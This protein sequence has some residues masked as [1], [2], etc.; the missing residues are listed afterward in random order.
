MA[1]LGEK[2]KGPSARSASGEDI[3]WRLVSGEVSGK[4]TRQQTG[5]IFLIACSPPRGSGLLLH[6]LLDRSKIPPYYD[7]EPEIPQ[8]PAVARALEAYDT[9]IRQAVDRRAEAR[10]AARDFWERTAGLDVPLFED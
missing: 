2:V 9:A 3:R 5:G 1:P 8:E 7:G 4:I 6:R 10:D